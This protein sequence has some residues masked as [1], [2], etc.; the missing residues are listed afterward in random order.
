MDDLFDD[1][2]FL[3]EEDKEKSAPEPAQ[4]PKQQI[5]FEIPVDTEAAPKPTPEPEPEVDQVCEEGDKDEHDDR[6]DTD[7]DDG[8]EPVAKE[9]MTPH[10]DIK[11][12][13]KSFK[14]TSDD[15]IFDVEVGGHTFRCC[16]CCVYFSL[17]ICVL[18]CR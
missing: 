9:R 12:S 17:T 16:I 4:D 10:D 6:D 13:V 8:G 11:V 3:R 14:A 15:F 18:F 2:P 7:E 1:S 5:S